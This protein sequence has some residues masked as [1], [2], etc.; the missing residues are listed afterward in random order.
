MSSLSDRE[1]AIR[2]KLKDD[3]P[4]YASRCLKIRPK[5]PRAGNQPLTLNRGQ[6][7]LH[8]CIE[9]QRAATGKVRA[10]VLKGRQ[11]GVST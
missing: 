9:Q 7:H 8:D 5:D 6:Q 10:L 4:H 2:Q 1:L 11:Q 3:F